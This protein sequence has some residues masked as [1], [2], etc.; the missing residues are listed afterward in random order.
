MPEVG[1]RRRLRGRVG[2]FSVLA[3][4]GSFAGK[5]TLRVLRVRGDEERVELTCG[6]ESYTP[7]EARDSK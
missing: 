6:Y 1:A 5:G 4:V 7:I 3:P 2:A